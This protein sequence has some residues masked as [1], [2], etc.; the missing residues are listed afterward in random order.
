MSKQFL[1]T[2]TAIVFLSAIANSS[3]VASTNRLL[4]NAPHGDMTSEAGEHSHATTEIPPGQPV[5][6]VDLIVHQDPKKG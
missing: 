5:P 6:S 1:L 4:A 3:G 2:S